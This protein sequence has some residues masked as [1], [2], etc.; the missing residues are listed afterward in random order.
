MSRQEKSLY[1]TVLMTPDMANFSGKVHGGALLKLLD[2]VAY[3]C[4]ARY[5]KAYVITAS[6]DLVTFK[7]PVE[8]GELVT[9]MANVNYVGTSS[10]EVG[11]KVMAENLRTKEKR[12]ASSCFFTMVAVGEDGR[13][14]T[15]PRL[16]IETDIE[17]RLFEAGK[18]RKEMRKEIQQRNDALHVRIP[19]GQTPSGAVT[20]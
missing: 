20:G 1:M 18:M 2:Q 3:A 4:A 10:M 11:V 8:V 17:Q 12:H 6:L 9:F 16:E 5:A 19:E 14:T 13:P 7:Q 15:V